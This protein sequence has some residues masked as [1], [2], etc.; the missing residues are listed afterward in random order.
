MVCLNFGAK[1][2]QIIDVIIDVCMY[3]CMYACITAPE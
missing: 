3:V 1:F 2:K